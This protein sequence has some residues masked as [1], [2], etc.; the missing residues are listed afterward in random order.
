VSQGSNEQED[1]ACEGEEKSSIHFGDSDDKLRAYTKRMGH[2]CL[3]P[4]RCFLFPALL[5]VLA[6]I[7]Q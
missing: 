4:G 2:D 3:W 7:A 6:R 1:D 5:F